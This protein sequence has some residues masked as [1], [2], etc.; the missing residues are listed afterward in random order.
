MTHSAVPDTKS[1][2]RSDSHERYT[3]ALMDT[4]WD[5]QIRAAVKQA[6]QAKAR[7]HGI[8]G[9]KAEDGGANLDRVGI[10]MMTQLVLAAVLD[11][12]QDIKVGGPCPLFPG[13]QSSRNLSA[14]RSP[15]LV[16]VSARGGVGSRCPPAR[17]VVR[18]ATATKHELGLSPFDRVVS[19]CSAVDVWALLVRLSHCQ[20]ARSEVFAV[21]PL[22]RAA[23]TRWLSV[24]I[25]EA[26]AKHCFSLCST[27]Q[28][29]QIQSQSDFRATQ[30]TGLTGKPL[31]N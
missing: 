31:P 7:A 20:R 11:S 2:W 10:F 30:R 21:V 26:V 19:H 18:A 24:V 29:S 15:Q 25:S 5:K 1:V 14:R 17:A 23:W 9:A 4:R 12:S 16:P 27:E 6:L 8:K 3:T 13:K 22:W 28:P